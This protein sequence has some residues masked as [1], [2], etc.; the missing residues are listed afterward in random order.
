MVQN[1]IKIVLRSIMRQKIYS[2]I[3][4]GGLAV[5]M[6]SAILIILWVQNE[7]N[8]DK[9]HK[10]G[11]EIYRLLIKTSNQGEVSLDP[12]TPYPLA[13]ALKRE[14]PE[15]VNAAVYVRYPKVLIKSKE[16][17]FYEENVSIGSAQFFKI[18]NFHF[19][20]GDPE[21]ALINPN[22]V[23]ITESMSNKYYNNESAR[24]KIIKIDTTLYQVTGI[25][26][27]IPD[28]SHIKFD[29]I[30][31]PH[32]FENRYKENIGWGNFMSRCYVRLESS[33][34]IHN[35]ANKIN[36]NILKNISADFTTNVFAKFELQPL[37]NIHLTNTIL[38]YIY[39]FSILAFFIL[40]I[41]CVN[42]INLS[43]AM[44][45]RR[46]KEVGI[47][48][49]VG[50]NRKQLIKQFLSESAVFTLMAT[51]LAFIIIQ[52]L[53]PSFKLL[54][55]KQIIMDLSDYQYVLIFIGVILLTCL[56][57]GIYPA[58]F[59]SSFNP[60]QMLKGGLKFGRNGINLRRLLVVYQ[61]TISIGLIIC[62][63]II[64]NQLQFM[65]T[66]DLGF[67]KENL[68]YIPLD[69]S[70][71]QEYN[72]FR[73]ELMKNPAISGVT[74]SLYLPTS[75]YKDRSDIEWDGKDPN[76]KIHVETP[77]VDDNYF[78]VI[79]LKI[80]EGRN[81]SKEFSTD[82]KQAIILNEAAVKSM[83]ISSPIGK[84]VTINGFRG[85]IIG[86][87]NDAH[88][89]PLRYALE[90]QAY[91]LLNDL[92]GVVR[93]V[94]I[95]KIKPS[96]SDK[97]M[98]ETIAA[99]KNEWSVFNPS[100]P[101]EY[102]FLNESIDKQY[103]TEQTISE[104]FSG[105]TVVAII[106]SCLGLFG[107]AS[108]TIQRR[109][110]EI[111]IRKVLGATIPEIIL[112]LSNEFMKWIIAANIIAWPIAYF[113]MN[114]WLQDFAYRI[115]INI[116][117]FIFSA[118]ISLFIALATISFQSIKSAIANPVDSIKYE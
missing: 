92:N 51:V 114:S 79:N 78:D 108:F 5:G 112:M 49:V 46:S 117:I 57:T 102:N 83:G 53:L 73:N 116:W 106:I 104:I 82:S 41:A 75:E 21:S 2:F 76:I 115:D 61:Y 66:K 54:T 18:F 63:L 16:K 55:K 1:Y 70:I 20:L 103:K 81:F 67:D 26:K 40:F 33:A 87:V 37:A 96:G 50:A 30:I 44:A 111:G 10:N 88:F 14:I 24:G 43:T 93:G 90:E 98:F 97:K 28:Q 101:F 29:F 99:I 94:V 91:T 89:L 64:S 68:I 100:Q 22:S 27:D 107:L 25:I 84:E 110:K 113:F 31:S 69:G 72:S 7:L 60:T 109:S 42:Y 34:N 65:R 71:K 6:A 9:F 56:M 13:E 105:F 86:I 12:D 3:N 32:E 77:S 47:R 52:L 15:V 36:T 58:F 62:T 23:V 80:K 4:I 59:T 8:Y 17:V 74:S 11:D 35:V 39:I 48:K 38:K 45:A 95:I 85:N 19:I 118:L